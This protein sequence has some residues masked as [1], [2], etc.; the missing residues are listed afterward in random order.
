MMPCWFRFSKESS[1][2]ICVAVW[3]EK[4]EI[5]CVDCV[6]C[7]LNLS[8][9]VELWKQMFEICLAVVLNVFA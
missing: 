7:F 4:G 1:L 2:I 5:C 6:D 8:A 3:S 9:S